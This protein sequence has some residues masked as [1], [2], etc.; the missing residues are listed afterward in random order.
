VCTMQWVCRYRQRG[1]DLNDWLAGLNDSP[2][3]FF[4][5]ARRDGARVQPSRLQPLAPEPVRTRLVRLERVRAAISVVLSLLT[6]HAH[7]TRDQSQHFMRLFVALSTRTMTDLQ[8]V[9]ALLARLERH[10]LVAQ[11]DRERWSP[12]I[13]RHDLAN[14][15]ALRLLANAAG[16]VTLHRPQSRSQPPGLGSNPHSA[17]YTQR[18]AAYLAMYLMGFEN[19]SFVG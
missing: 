7:T 10:T 16:Q 9:D 8:L 14:T 1:T 4:D 13:G 11:V 15:R 12:P 18:A 5:L 2:V 3:L 19:C 17:H 6:V